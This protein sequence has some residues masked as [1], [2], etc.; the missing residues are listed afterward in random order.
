MVYDG[1]AAAAAVIGA[2][3]C[4]VPPKEHRS[5]GVIILFFC[6]GVQL[7]PQ[8]AHTFSCAPLEQRSNNYFLIHSLSDEV[9][10]LLIFF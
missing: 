7:R 3:T 1:S 8:V 6:L 4:Y 2:G 5:R 10:R 9:S